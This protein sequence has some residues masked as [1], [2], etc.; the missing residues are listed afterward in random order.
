[1]TKRRIQRVLL[2][3]AAATV[4]AM[5]AGTREV[6]AGSI[7]VGVGVGQGGDPF[8]VYDL[9][10]TLNAGAYLPQSTT[11]NP[12]S[13]D[14]TFTGLTGLVSNAVDTTSIVSQNPAFPTAA[15]LYTIG[16]DKI[17]LK[18][19]NAQGP[20]GPFSSNLLLFDLR[21]QTPD[22]QTQTGLTPGSTV[23]FTYTIPGQS[24][25]SGSVTVASIPEPSTVVLTL[26]GVAGMPLL[27]RRARRR[28][29]Q[30]AA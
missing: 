13:L 16:T 19:S 1:M 9:T 14:L 10:V 5:F 17:E 26:L 12:I 3:A 2:V 27:V 24:G 18:E 8:F 7:S 21:I 29:S 25:G 28:S 4:G 6:R 23:N 11:S 20:I 30:P 15:W 22:T